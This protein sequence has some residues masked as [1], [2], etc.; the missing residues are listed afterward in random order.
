MYLAH[1]SEGAVKS[2]RGVT[3]AIEPTGHGPVLFD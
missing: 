1:N 2:P 3:F